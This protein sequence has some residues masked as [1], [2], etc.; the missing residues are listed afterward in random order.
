MLFFGQ[1]SDDLFK[2]AHVALADVEDKVQF[3]HTD[4][5]SC[6]SHF[7]ASAP[8]IVFTRQFETKHNVYSGAADKDELKKWFKPL[9]VPTLF[10]FTEE[11]IDPVFGQQQNTLFLFREQA[12]DDAAFVKAYAAASEANKGKVLFAFSDKSNDI[13]GKLAEFMGITDEDLPT[14]R[15]LKPAAMTKYKYEGSVKDMTIEDIT[16]FIDGINSGT[17]KAHL[18][19]EPVPEKNDGPVTV[20]VGHEFEKIVKDATKDV[21]VKYYAPWCGH[22]KK[23]APVWDEL[24]E[25]YKDNQDIVIAKFDA[26]ANEAEGVNVRGYPTLIWYPKDNKEGVNYEGDRDLESFKKFL[27]ENAFSLKNGA[28]KEAV[29]EDL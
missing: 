19:S 28:P 13:Q 7:G 3:F 26:T 18:K 6:A 23:L 16:T 20:I 1:E 29:K 24:G 12:D 5:A 21:L 17:I 15:F 9:T 4:D 11:E 25:F 2:N 14:M 8:S 10:K 27:N 22:C